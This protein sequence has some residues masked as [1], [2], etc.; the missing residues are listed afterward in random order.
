MQ[1]NLDDGYHNPILQ[2]SYLVEY[3]FTHSQI[4]MLMKLAPH[5]TNWNE[6]SQ[7]YELSHVCI[8]A[9]GSWLAFQY[10]GILAFII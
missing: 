10:L 2:Q 4:F 9:K 5:C 7:V 3:L 6:H 8:S 1:F